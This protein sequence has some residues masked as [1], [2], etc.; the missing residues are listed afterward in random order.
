[1]I[2][3]SGINWDANTWKEWRKGE[4]AT[5]HDAPLVPL[6][7]EWTCGLDLLLLDGG[8]FYGPAEFDL[9][10]SNV[11][12]ERPMFIA[13]HDTNAFKNYRSRQILLGA[14]S[15]YECIY[16]EVTGNG[17][18]I[19]R[20]VSKKQQKLSSRLRAVPVSESIT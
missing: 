18:S 11:E 13:I 19:F 1:M 8:E 6:T 14:R 10:Y 9:F 12:C 5:E 4:I 16:D 20:R 7:Y 15:G 3:Q 2:Q 17:A